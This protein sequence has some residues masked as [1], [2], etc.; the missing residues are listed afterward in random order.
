[1]HNLDKAYQISLIHYQEGLDN[2]LTLATI[3]Q[4]QFSAKRVQSQIYG[5]QFVSAVGLIKALGGGWEGLH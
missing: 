1:V 4:N 3:Q 2:A 5:S